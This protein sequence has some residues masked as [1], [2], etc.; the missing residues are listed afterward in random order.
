MFDATIRWIWQTVLLL[1]MLVFPWLMLSVPTLVHVPPPPHTPPTLGY[2]VSQSPHPQLTIEPY[3]RPEF[4]AW[5]ETM[6]PAIRQAAAR[7]N[8]PMLSGMDDTQ[9]AQ[10]MALIL[11]NEHNGWVEDAIE[12]LRAL[13]PLYQQAQIVANQQGLGSNFSM[14]PTNLRP[15]V[16]L[17]MLQQQLPVPEPTGV[18]TVPIEVQGSRIVPGDYPSQRMLYAA[19]SREV[20]DDA[21]AVEYLAVNL[22]RGVYRAQYEG[23]P[24][25][26]RTLAAWHNQGIVHPEQIRANKTARDYLRRTTA[27]LPLSQHLMDRDQEIVSLSE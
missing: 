10:V 18:I 15:S 13:T 12:P 26:W 19:I 7:H 4:A 5:M 23:V 2:C 17:E 3:V 6:R 16:A 14:W 9:F 22:E 25:S 27:Y 24:I 20:V 8:R 21:L 1:I 11:Y